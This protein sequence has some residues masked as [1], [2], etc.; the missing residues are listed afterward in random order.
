MLLPVA[1]D[2]FSISTR[3]KKPVS[4]GN[5]PL[6]GIPLEVDGHMQ[7]TASQK[8]QF[9]SKGFCEEEKQSRQAN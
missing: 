9:S 5:S 1:V 6:D 8:M 4:L 2:F 3:K 7:C